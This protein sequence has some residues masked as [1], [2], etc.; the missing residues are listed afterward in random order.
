MTTTRILNALTAA[1]MPLLFAVAVVAGTVQVQAPEGGWYGDPETLAETQASKPV[2]EWT[3]ADVAALWAGCRAVQDSAEVNRVPAA[4][5]VLTVGNAYVRM[6][7]PEVA[8]RVEA[9][10][11]TP[12]GDSRDVAKIIGTCY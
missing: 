3:D 12:R 8:D 11:G 2:N 10:G 9:F 1:L 5:V 6:P 4:H 7:Q